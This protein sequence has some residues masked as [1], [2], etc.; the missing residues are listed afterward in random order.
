MHN[1]S[2]MADDHFKCTALSALCNVGIIMV[3]KRKNIG[4]RNS[5]GYDNANIFEA[6][7]LLSVLPIIL[8]SIQPAD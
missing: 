7:K 6:N 1:F 2:A 3:V 4:K 5:I 8:K